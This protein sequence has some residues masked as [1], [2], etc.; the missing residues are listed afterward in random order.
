MLA[1]LD[2]VRETA[3]GWTASCPAHDDQT[4]SLSIRE[5]TQGKVLLKC[6]TEVRN[7]GWRRASSMLRRARVRSRAAP[8]RERSGGRS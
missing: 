1:N 8:L 6:H 4:P 2:Q 7:L 5:G 3:N